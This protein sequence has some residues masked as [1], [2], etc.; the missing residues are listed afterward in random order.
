MIETKRKKRKEK[1]MK[2]FTIIF[3]ALIMSISSQSCS[4]MQCIID[5]IKSCFNT[6]CYDS[7][8]QG[9][10]EFDRGMVPTYLSTAE[11]SMRSTPIFTNLTS[12]LCDPV[13][14]GRCKIG[15]TLCWATCGC[16]IV[17][18][19]CLGY[20]NKYNRTKLLKKIP[21]LVVHEA[22]SG[23]GW[24]PIHVAS[25]FGNPSDVRKLLEYGAGPNDL[26]TLPGLL[27]HSERR[28]ELLWLT[29]Q[30]AVDEGISNFE[31]EWAVENFCPAPLHLAIYKY[32]HDP[33]L[34]N[35]IIIQLIE[36]GADLDLRASEGYDQKKI[37][38]LKEKF[39]EAFDSLNFGPK[40]TP[41]SLAKEFVFYKE[42]CP[43]FEQG[44]LRAEARFNA[45]L[46]ELAGV[47]VDKDGLVDCR[48]LCNIIFQ[49]I[50][51]PTN[52]WGKSRAWEVIAE[53]DDE[54]KGL[55]RKREMPHARVDEKREGKSLRI[56]DEDGAI[57]IVNAAAHREPVGDVAD[58]FATLSL[59]DVIK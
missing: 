55:D 57:E 39:G 33:D 34:Y 17:G 38:R 26:T 23:T 58:A 9:P 7:R 42:L 18:A 15:K 47:V 54:V 25:W 16:C 41:R 27:C 4:A 11:G 19:C 52:Q 40:R 10:T 50:Q 36:Y 43:I 45:I 24:R 30:G 8:P 5:G 28:D 44:K 1:N 51:I 56:H 49:Y 35:T 6:C 48:P 21:P 32:R 22:D 14:C 20:I 29:H 12:D 37:E 59:T 2:K 53:E 31:T 3:L 13:V 46:A